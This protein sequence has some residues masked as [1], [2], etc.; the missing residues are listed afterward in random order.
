MRW[1]ITIEYHGGGFVGWQRQISGMSIQQALEEAVHKFSGETQRVTGAGRTDAGVHALGQVAHFD[2]EKNT[3]GEV[4]RDALNAHLQPL[5]ISVLSAQIVGADFDARL[6]A[7]RR[8]YRYR[9]L[10][11]RSPGAIDAGLVWHVPKPLNAEAM[12]EAAQ[13]LLGKHD[14]ST[15]R[16][17]QCQAKSPIKTLEAIALAR[18]G[19]EIVLTVSA[20]S[21]LH[22]QVRNIIGTLKFVGEGKWSAADI[23]AALEACERSAGGPTAPP[24]GLYFV[25]VEY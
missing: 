7:K 23:R 16:A 21:F 22:H 25:Q 8:H 17:A 6:R 2:L 18:H 5:P 10:N 9:I 15:F 3:T 11:R 12:H 1:K 14:F 24:C 20:P 4:V 13:C 19:D